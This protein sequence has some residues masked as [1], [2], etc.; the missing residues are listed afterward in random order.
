MP[1]FSTDGEQV[2]FEVVSPG[3]GIWIANADGSRRRQV[4]ETNLLG[5]PASPAFSPDARSIAFFQSERGLL[6]DI[7]VTASEGGTP[8]RLTFD[9]SEG[10][11]PV[12]T[13]D[14]RFIIYYSSRAGA[15]TLWRIPAEGGTPEPITS[16][17]GQDR[18]PD[19]SSDGKHLVYSNF[20][21]THALMLHDPVRGEQREL[22]QR[23]QIVGMPRFSSDATRI[24]FSQQLGQDAHVFTIGIDGNDLRQVTDGPGQQNLAPQWSD[25]TGWL[26]F[27]RVRPTASLRKVSVLGGDSVEVGSWSEVA[28]AEIDP[29]G[30]AVAYVRANEGQPSATVMRSLTNGRETVLDTLLNGPRWSPDAQTI[31]G[32]ATRSRRSRLARRFV[33]CKSGCGSGCGGARL[34]AGRG[35]RRITN[36]LPPKVVGDTRQARALVSPGERSGREPPRQPSVVSRLELRRLPRRRDRLHPAS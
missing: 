26:H 18:D 23:R 14:G 4:A 25:D 16:G 12:W 17:A 28:M 22:L 33:R 32:M 29:T 21:V 6:G 20:R 30:T 24:A 3:R 34:R 35:A 19:I 13:P 11:G 2:V 1:R 9:S 7:W 31:C 10:G 8:R 5:A 15:Q 36:P 27:F